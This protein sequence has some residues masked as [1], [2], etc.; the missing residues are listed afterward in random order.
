[1]M[2]GR[3]RCG[4]GIVSHENGRTISRVYGDLLGL[5][6]IA[7]GYL[8]FLLAFPVGYVFWRT[9]RHGF[10]PAWSEGDDVVAA[11]GPVYA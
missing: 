3:Q 9:F 10:W 2:K 4:H 8:A 5:R 6:L 11:R 1:M 7:L